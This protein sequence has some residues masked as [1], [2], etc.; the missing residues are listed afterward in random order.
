MPNEEVTR[1]E[2]LETKRL[3]EALNDFRDQCAKD[4]LSTREFEEESV[5]F[6]TDKYKRFF[7]NSKWAQRL[8][9]LNNAVASTSLGYW[10]YRSV[11]A[12]G[13][14]N[15]I[16]LQKELSK[17]ILPIAFYTGITCRFWAYICSCRGWDIT[18]KIF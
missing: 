15:R 2:Q 7:F 13:T 5:K 14:T 11:G 1:F 18:F 12:L 4:G 16:L 3:T 6:I 10:G 17:S 8:Y 9:K